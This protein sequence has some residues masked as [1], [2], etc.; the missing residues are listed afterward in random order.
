MHFQAFSLYN[1]KRGNVQFYHF[2]LLLERP[3]I[4]KGYSIS[5]VG[6]KF[7]TPWQN[8]RHNNKHYRKKK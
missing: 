3:K 1:S 8:I 6:N 5:Q 7:T 4:Q 2:M